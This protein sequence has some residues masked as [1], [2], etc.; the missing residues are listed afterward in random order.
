MRALSEFAVERMRQIIQ[1]RSIDPKPQEPRTHAPANP[2]ADTELIGAVNA[3]YSRLRHF[4][5]W[6]RSQHQ[7]NLTELHVLVSV[8]SVPSEG[9]G[10]GRVSAAARLAKEVEL[11]PSGLTRLVDR[12]VARG[13]LAR[14][15]DTWDQRVTHLVLTKTGLAMRNAIIPQATKHIRA[16]CDKHQSLLDRLNRIAAPPRDERPLTPRDSSGGQQS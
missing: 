7:L 15:C 5:E 16:T 11:S 1:A 6:L 10:L 12:L 14:L 3:M 13:L 2:P 9:R 8:P 4:D